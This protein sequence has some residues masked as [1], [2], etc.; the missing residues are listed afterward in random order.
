[1]ADSSTLPSTPL[2]SSRSGGRHLKRLS[3]GSSLSPSLSSASPSSAHSPATSPSLARSIGRSAGSS[4]ARALRA[5]TAGGSLFG[6]GDGNYVSSPSSTSALG[7][8]SSRN[9][10]D[11]ARAESPTLPRRSTSLRRSTSPLPPSDPSSGSTTPVRRTPSIGHGRRGASISYTAS[12]PAELVSPESSRL[13]PPSQ[14]AGVEATSPIPRRSF[15]STSPL[16]GVQEEDDSEPAGSL[17]R[18]SI[19][20]STTASSH[21]DDSSTSPSLSRSA[22][23]TPS[24]GAGA[25]SGGMMT[26][27]TLVEQNADLLSFIAKKERKCLDLREDLS[28]A[29]L[30]RHESE[31]A[32]LKK[33]WE[34]IVARSLQQQAYTSTSS[35]SAHRAHPSISSG[36]PNTS[37]TPRPHPT[38]PPTHSLDLSLLSS[39]FDAPPNGDGESSTPIEIPESVKAAGTWI[40][41]ALGRVLEVAVGMPTG[42]EGHNGHVQGQ[43]EARGLGIVREEEEEEGEEGEKGERRDRSSMDGAAVASTSH[44]QARDA[45]S[46]SSGTRPAPPRTSSSPTLSRS[47]RLFS[48]PPSASSPST[49]PTHART[50]S[51]LSLL[52]SSL[53]SKWAQLSSSEV[54]QNSKR[55]TMG[56]V[57]T[58]EQGL[59]QALGPLELPPI[60]GEGRD[61]RRSRSEEAPSPFLRD[62]SA[63]EKAASAQQRPAP[64]RSSSQ[65]QRSNG[66]SLPNFGAVPGQGL[67]SMFA[68][69]SSAV[70]SSH[71]TFPPP[72]TSNPNADRTPTASTFADASSASTA[73]GQGGWDWSAFLPASSSLEGMA[74]QAGLGGSNGKERAAEDGRRLEKGKGRETE[75]V[76]EDVE[77]DWP[78]W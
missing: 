53:S 20:S 15:D 18:A 44:S 6:A 55:A 75:K 31:L 49:S 26:Q 34:S 36:S 8:S 5:G 7:L 39:T 58:F 70:S 16:P 71:T 13:V 62:D 68:S 69:L 78:G 35:S 41:G 11:P 65:Q 73:Q 66:Q 59:A 45:E 14:G 32:L 67:S 74:E 3:L 24:A 52:S 56:L 19:S 76:R 61:E 25:G 60:E 64:L 29:E 63:A 50:R 1:M 10:E 22:A 40:G 43:Q 72:P 23:T 28:H 12:S 51:S 17:H 46:T 30:K 9:E 77:D 27:A 38:L 4:D 2:G 47:S 48:P 42:M 37:P 54:V 21:A 57:D 33:K